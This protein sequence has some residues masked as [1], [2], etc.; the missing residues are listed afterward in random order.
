MTTNDEDIDM[1]LAAANPLHEADLGG[2]AIEEALDALYPGIVGHEGAAGVAPPS[3]R[4]R[5]RLSRGAAVAI[6]GAS[7]LAVGGVAAAVTVPRFIDTR[8][9]GFAATAVQDAAGIPFP[10]GDSARA[11]VPVV[12]PDAG[13]MSP[14]GPRFTL[15]LD[16]ACAWEG[17]WLQAHERSDTV[18]QAAAVRVLDEVPNWATIRD[19]DG[20]GVVLSFQNVARAAGAGEPGPVRQDWTANCTDLPRRW[21]T[22]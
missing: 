6:A 19:H 9:P 16:A 7:V 21:A 10:P 8:D 1:L 17:Y 3:R 2:D 13:L 12:F 5:R 18:A 14:D 22:K 15:A 4:P 11:Y 20:G